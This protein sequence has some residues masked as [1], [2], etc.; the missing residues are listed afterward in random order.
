LAKAKSTAS[1]KR[2]K[3]AF[4]PEELGLDLHAVARRVEAVECMAVCVEQALLERQSDSD[5]VLAVCV[6]RFI[7]DELKS[8][9]STLAAL[10]AALDEGPYIPL[11]ESPILGLRIQPVQG[12]EGPQ[13]SLR[14]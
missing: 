2:K 1:R 5:R 9:C 13:G 11:L 4:D 12:Q 8:V 3:W 7:A 10:M 6:E 14:S